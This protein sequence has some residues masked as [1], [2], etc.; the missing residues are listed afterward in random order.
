[1]L[2]SEAQ[3]PNGLGAIR[4]LSFFQLAQRVI[5]EVQH[6]LTANEIWEIAQE[7]GYDKELDTKGKTPWAT[8]AA[9]LY[10]DVRDNPN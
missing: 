5:K 9:R 8:L 4:G 3:H 7:K 2:F 6:P 10:V 1:M